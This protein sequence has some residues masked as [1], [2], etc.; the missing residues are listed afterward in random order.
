VIG[1]SQK[2][3]IYFDE[4][5][6]PIMKMTSIRMINCFVNLEFEQMDVKTS[7]QHGELEEYMEQPEGLLVKGKEDYV[8]K[9]NKSLYELN[10]AAIQWYMKF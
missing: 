8:C 3:G 2:K 1:F 10:Q 5:F 6:S 4:I 7:F 9:M